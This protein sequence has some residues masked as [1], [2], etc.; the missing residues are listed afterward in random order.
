[1]VVALGGG[2]AVNEQSGTRV[3]VVDDD[4]DL[5][6]SYKGVLEL[7]GY[8]VLIALS[9]EAALSLARAEHPDVVLTEVSMP[10]MDGFELINRLKNE[11]GREAPP[12]VVC[13]AFEI[14]EQE[15]TE[16]GAELFLQKPATASALVESVEAVSQ[17]ERPAA[18]TITSER[19]HAK[20]ERL[21]HIH[22]SE[23]RLRHLD[24]AELAAEAKPWL[25]WM[26]AYFD[27]G[28]AGVFLLEG[29][30]VVPLA[31]VGTQMESRPEPRLLHAVLAAGV[32]TGTSLVVRDMTNHPSFRRALGPR[33]DIATF[34]GVPIVTSDGVR[35]G[36]ICLADPRPGRLDAD[37][38]EMMEHLG[39]RG[40][41]SLFG[42][43]T[44]PLHALPPTAPLLSRRTF[45]TLLA[46]EL[47]IARRVN[48]S[49]EVA[50]AELAPGIS[51]AEFA[52]QAWHE[53][54]RPRM[55]IGT[56]GSG[57]IAVFA[58]GAAGEVWAHVARLIERG[59]A[60]NRLEFVGIAGVAASA[61][62]SRNAVFEIAESA[63]SVAQT[64]R[65]GRGV[66]RIVVRPESGKPVA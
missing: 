35:I 42:K 8:E 7:A 57:R 22:G 61:G 46:A 36:A 5:V 13:S 40:I 60:R 29:D 64:D 3:L 63:L 34:A 20:H 53:E 41:V 24:R 59:R 27:C 66:E 15:V 9:G 4:R 18:E 21:R 28:N 38:L 12:V 47:R 1:L 19:S 6:E 43:P 31:V 62:L 23:V 52:V 2:V 10:N 45:D 37:S 11:L 44:S 56:V 58:R 25:E 33:P 48:E 65:F 39:R 26:R 54:P 14:T 50:L 32:E 16:R 51:P 17:G 49:V 30:A 55:A